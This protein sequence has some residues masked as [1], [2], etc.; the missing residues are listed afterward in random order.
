VAE[1]GTRQV[2]QQNGRPYTSLRSKRTAA[3]LSLAA[4]TR[5]AKCVVLYSSQHVACAACA[6]YDADDG[7]MPQLADG[8]SGVQACS[9]QLLLV[10]D[11]VLRQLARDYPRLM[12]FQ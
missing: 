8:G 5:A 11:V 7:H 4:G 1:V 10:L 6:Q 2:G 9:P 12:A 3:L